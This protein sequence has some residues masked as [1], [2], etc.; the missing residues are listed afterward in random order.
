VGY[1]SADL[2]NHSVANAV[3]PILRHH[4]HGRV[5]VA[6]Y[7]GVTRPDHVTAE[8]RALAD[9][10]HDVAELSDDDLAARIRADQVDILVDLSGHSGGNRLPVFAREP[11][12]IQVTAWGYGAGTGLDAMHYFLADPIAVPPEH[13][14]TYAEQ[15]VDLPSI[16]CYEPPAHAPAVA[17]PPAGAR[18]YVT[19]GA[20]NRL[21]KITA[22]TLETWARVLVAVPSARLVI[23]CVGADAPSER[24]HL[25]GSLSEHGVHPDRVTILGR[26]SQP[27]HL[28]AHGGVD[29]MLDTFPQSGGITTM[30]ALLMGVPVVTLL[31][32]RVTGRASASF[33]TTLGLTDL[34]AQ[35]PDEYVEIAARLA[36]DLERLARERATLRERLLTS[37]L[38]DAALYTRAVEAAYREI[39][40][41]WCTGREAQR[42]ERGA[43]GQARAVSKVRVRPGVV[44]RARAGAA[45]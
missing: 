26:T 3:L 38:G 9:R 39:W 32:Q 44:V 27:D 18:G 40:H 33:L 41:R 30:D 45:R 24:D 23:K 11:A 17:P 35:T 10:W 1:V 6:C 16:L 13:R 15:I 42:E 37:P 2:R 5:S 36:G 29:L 8:I 7:S 19:F 28:A 22:R 31:G 43:S 14:G 12:P 4:D 21:P 25:L 34:V 20:F